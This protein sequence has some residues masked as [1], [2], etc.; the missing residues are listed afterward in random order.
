[1]PATR[2]PFEGYSHLSL[3]K[4]P[5]NFFCSFVLTQK[6]QK[7][8]PKQRFDAQRLHTPAVLAGLR[9]TANGIVYR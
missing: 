8:K 2:L 5:T 6:N 1:M 7:V 9:A 4:Q 3:T